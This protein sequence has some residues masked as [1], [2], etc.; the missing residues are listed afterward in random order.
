MHVVL[1][2]TTL[3]HMGRMSGAHTSDVF[4]TN[5]HSDSDAML[6]IMDFM[7][8]GDCQSMYASWKLRYT[9]ALRLRLMIPKTRLMLSL[10]AAFFYGVVKNICLCVPT[11]VVCNFLS[12][13]L[14][15]F[16]HVCVVRVT[17]FFGV[18]FWISHC[19]LAYAIF[20][21]PTQAQIG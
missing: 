9:H 21:E 1:V 8:A 4:V 11:R 19:V 2:F 12:E 15:I 10:S 3:R 20:P 14:R 13:A 18:R 16:T 17:C 7:R 6:S 5:S